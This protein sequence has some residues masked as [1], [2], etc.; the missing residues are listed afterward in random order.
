MHMMAAGFSKTPEMMLDQ[1]E[2]ALLANA[3]NQVQE[4]YAFE[5]SAEVMLWT[6]VI[7][8]LAAI[9]GP[10]IVAV[11]GRK[12][13]EKKVKK[14]EQKQQAEII[15]QTTEGIYTPHAPPQ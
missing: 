8:V 3:I 5:A 15:S 6:N 14:Q 7:G 4:H 13:K 12:S 1:Q 11:A 10:R 9:Y 2:A